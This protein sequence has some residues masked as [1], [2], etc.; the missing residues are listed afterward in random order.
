[1]K[2]ST[3]IAFG[4]DPQRL[5]QQAQD[6]EAAGVDLLWAP[7]IYGFD[8]ITTLAYIAATTERVELMT[9]IIPLYSRSPALIAQT[10]ATLDALSGGRFVLGLGTS[11]PQVIEGWH[12]V[13][14]AQP[15]A[16]T[17]DT[18]EICKKVWS[19]DKVS[20]D[21]VTYQLPMEGGT[22]LGK[23]LRWMG[24]PPRPD[25]PIALATIGPKNVELTAEVA[26]IWQTIH[27]VPDRFEQV[28]GE[29]LATG[30]AK[31]DPEKKPLEIMAGSFVALGEGDHIQEA[32]D[33][34]RNLIGFYVGG[35]GA[36]SKNFYNDLFKRYG[37]EQE[38][39]EIQDLFLGGKRGEAMAAV[40]EEYIDLSSLIGDEGYV[41][42]RL[43]VFKEV[44]VTHLNV[45]PM[46]PDSLA[47]FEKLKAWSE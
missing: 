46:G 35:M 11:G 44:G 25:I 18:V 24:P 37:W 12:G 41:R 9:G 34:A 47:T 31:R 15:I 13:P 40:P 29:S 3:T 16:R 20:H 8:A 26:D 28:W 27:F 14:F 6:L 10:A 42:E 4:G 45:N 19:G 39:E 36:K 32:R 33:A 21:G 2:I 38:A 7:E 5:A 43:Q 1:M 23:A 22:G 30:T 17:R